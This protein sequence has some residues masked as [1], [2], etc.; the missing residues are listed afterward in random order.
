M[1]SD[2]MENQPQ[3]QLG[4]VL[5]LDGQSELP[6][7]E[8]STPW[9]TAEIYLHGAHVTG[10]K[11]KDEPPLLFI[12]QCSR[13]APEQP[14]RGGIPV[15]FPW[16]GMREGLPQHGFA[17]LKSWDLK[18]VSPAPDGSVSVRFR[19]P[20]CPEASAFPPFTADYTVT[21]DQSLTLRL[22][23]TNNSHEDS[24]TFENCLHTYF[25]VG[26]VS[27]IS[28]A[29]LKGA[30]YLDKVDNFAQKTET[31]AAIH[32]TSEVDRVYLDTADKVEIMDPR[33]ARKIIIEKHGSLS[34]VVWNPWSSKA[35]QMPD[36]GNDEHERMVCVESGN[37]ARN[38]V[39]LPPGESSVLTVRISS[40]P[41]K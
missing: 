8:V 29:G 7:L 18:E 14:I 9:S 28:V 4:H 5:F 19:L 3:R 17:R 1:P 22:L 37:V 24:F 16:F 15:I 36:F 38:Q 34:T 10:F 23:V 2:Q 35:Q 11:K 27:R 33:N 20:E 6:M 25:E 32:I 12:S 26:D 41:I 40:E 30:K 13:F 39:T 21:V 31:E